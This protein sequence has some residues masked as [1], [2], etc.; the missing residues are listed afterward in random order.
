MSS[1]VY[2]V[3]MAGGGGSRFWPLSKKAKPKQ[4]L[5][6]SKD[7]DSMIQMTAKRASLFT[8]NKVYVLTNKMYEGIVKEHLGDVNL[9]MEPIARNTAA[10][11][12][13]AAS[14]LLKKDKDAVMVVW[15]SDHVITN[16]DKLKET[17]NEAIKL[18]NT[19]KCL[20]T[21]GINPEYP[22]TG[23]G[24]IELSD[25]IDG[26]SYK[27]KQFVE[28]PKLEVAKEYVASKRFLWNSGMFVWRAD[29][30][31]EEIKK[32]MPSLYENLE[33]ISDKIGTP[34]E[35][36]AIDEYFPKFESQSID[37]GVMEKASNVCVVK[38]DNLGWNDVGSLKEWGENF[39]KD[40]NQNVNLGNGTLLKTTNSICVSESNVPTFVIGMD[41]VIV[42]NTGKE[43]LVCNKDNAQDVKI[44]VEELKKQ[45]RKDL[46]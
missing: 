29:V 14:Y 20:V 24:Y 27:V 34:N 39:K 42:V 6:I 25:H 11:I 16:S 43:V 21:V 32:H 8:D 4:F 18:A 41:N 26:N 17:F 31:L 1:N 36:E 40:D 13:L 37:F 5:S 28:K 3:I 38:S 33:L 12:A 35:Q 9:I 22:H 2:V 7:G 10:P 19:K 46:L 44:I 15:P 45:D 23:Y 30:I